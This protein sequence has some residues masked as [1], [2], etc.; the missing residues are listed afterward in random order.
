MKA[1]DTVSLEAM[2][3]AA[4]RV[5][6]SNRVLI[7]T[8]A[9]VLTEVLGGKPLTTDWAHFPDGD[10]FDQQSASQF[11]FHAHEDRSGEA[12]HF[13]TFLRAPAIRE[14]TGED[15]EDSAVVHLIAVAIDRFGQPVELFTTN[16]WVTGETWFPAETVIA[17]L[18]RFEIDHAAPSWPLNIWI[19]ELLRLFRPDITRL[20]EERDVFIDGRLA[21][22]G[23]REDIFEDRAIEVCSSLRISLDRQFNKL[24]AEL[25]RRV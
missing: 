17:A 16:R 7:R 3:Q 6:E 19:T 5:R 8:G 18:E 22:G 4:L 11:Y 21:A 24:N 14:I 9:S 2:Q 15:V 20:I 23:S 12:G 13:H 25:A 1:L 10:I